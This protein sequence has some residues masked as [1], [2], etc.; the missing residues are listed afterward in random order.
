MA[1]LVSCA[2]VWPAQSGEVRLVWNPAT[3][4]TDG[5][6]LS[7]LPVYRV[8]FGQTARNYSR[9]QDAGGGTSATI[10]IPEEGTTFFFAVKA[11]NRAGLESAFSS[12]VSARVPD[13]T[14]P[15]ITPPAAVTIPATAHSDSAPAPD[16]ATSLTVQDNCS[17][18]SAI[19]VQQ[20]PATNTLLPVGNNTMTLRATDEAGNTSSCSVAVKVT[21]WVNTPPRL[22][23]PEDLATM[24][25]HTV[26][27]DVSAVDPD[28]SAVRL[29]TKGAPRFGAVATPQGFTFIDNR[30]GTGRF[31]WTPSASDVGD[32]VFTIEVSDGDSTSSATVLIHVSSF[33][34]TEPTDGEVLHCGS[35]LRIGWTSTVQIASVGIELWSGT[36]LL[37]ALANNLP[38]LPRQASWTTTVPMGLPPGSNFSVMVTN[39]SNP[40]DC[41]SSAFFTVLPLAVNDFNA[42]SQSDLAVY[43]PETA[44][45]YI[46]S[47]TNGHPIVYDRNWGFAG[48]IPVPG[49]YDGDGATD[50]AVFHPDSGTWYIQSVSKNRALAFG[51]NWG[52][53]G[54]MPVPGDYDG[55]GAFDLAVFHESSGNWYIGSLVSDTPIACGAN[56]GF[57]GC[58]AVPGDYDGDGV[59]DLAVYNKG[60]GRWY[61]RSLRSAEPIKFD[62]NWGFGGCEPVT[63]DY[64]GDGT[65][66]LSV[67]MPQAGDWYIRSIATSRVLRWA[68]NWGFWGCV[69]VPGDYNGDGMTD[70]TVYWPNDGSWYI[71]WPAAKNP[72]FDHLNW[73]WS[74]ATPAQPKRME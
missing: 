28:G 4:N 53:H 34:V 12:E 32:N 37:K 50:M 44:K 11:Y 70:M 33:V 16:L 61:I 63:G 67:F 54:C 49:D 40:A 57:Q 51:K 27:F 42:D 6:A 5:T 21:A 46:R 25:G 20:V 24:V 35:I 56:W 48:C 1:C 43:C 9:A 13:T 74:R 66:D 68:D 36:N 31:S 38:M 55:D 71:K 62:E 73:G 60:S 47:R 23:V 17:P 69:A 59:F 30:N 39:A 2:A 58:E 22:N 64:D 45:W 19:R 26:S 15:R 10:V 7:D 52:F 65:T 14:P 72:S 29:D 41:A 8:H 3:T 18:R